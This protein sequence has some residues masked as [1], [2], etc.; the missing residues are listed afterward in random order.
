MLF[1]SSVYAAYSTAGPKADGTGV[2]S[3]GWYLTPAGTQ[4]GLGNFPMDGAVSPDKKYF[5]A[6]NAGTGTQSL[7]VVDTQQQKVV[8]TI[9][10]ESPEALYIGLAF[11]PDG[12][13]LYASAG[14]NN[15]IR[16][17]NFDKGSLT[18]QSPIMMKDDKNT[19]FFILPE[20]LCPLT[21][22]TF[23]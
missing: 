22:N 12:K 17:F 16:V 6:A 20:C 2:T 14:G 7:Q 13:K 21:A 8:Q 10:Y 11:S 5:V 18:E 15:K 1:G 19:N 4:V 3:G 23:M 9:S